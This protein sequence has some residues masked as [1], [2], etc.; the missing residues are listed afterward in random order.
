MRILKNQQLASYTSLGV[1]GPADVLI[2]IETGDDITEIIKGTHEK[3][4]W[5]LGYGAN[6]L[7]S[8]RG[9]PGTTLVLRSGSIVQS[10]NT[11]VADAGASWDEIVMSAIAGRLWGLELMS[12]IP[13]SV[14]AAV[15]GNIAAYGQAVKDTLEWV[16]LVNTNT[17]ETVRFLPEQLDFAYRTSILQRPDMQMWCVT[18]AAFLLSPAQ[19]K[20]LQYHS[21]LSVAEELGEP[22]ETLKGLRR[23]ILET[24]RRLGS[25]LEPGSKSAG[26]FFRNPLVSAEQA[27]FIAGF[28]ETGK[29]KAIIES[30][31]HIHGG[32]ATRVS[33][34]LV[35]LAAEFS[36]GQSWGNV[37]LH[38][39]H[40]LK[41]ENIANA[42]AQDIYDVSAEIIQTVQDK[43]HITLE[44][45]V[46]FLGEFS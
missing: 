17:H 23:T 24:R 29:S 26:S 39:D 42:S 40:V 7:I 37:R 18:K 1:G 33:A 38:P 35:L 45:E 22:S 43:L 2:E 14:G 27:D 9:L 3:P 16:E 4:L 21:A 13:G 19:L 34:A 41:I 30:Q 28:D 6:S 5:L 11:L 12:G 36:R 8:D 20:P 32:D 25:L 15:V 46:R 31:H 10:G 44:P